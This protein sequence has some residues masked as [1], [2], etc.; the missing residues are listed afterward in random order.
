MDFVLGWVLRGIYVALGVGAAIWAFRWFKAN[1][2]STRERW[3]VRIAAAM[4]ILA[5]VY[6]VAHARLLLQRTEIEAARERY[7]VFGDPRRTELR[8]AEVRGW[9]LDCTGDPE[10]ALALYRERDGVVEREYPLGEG[11]ANFIGGGAD[12][13]V[14]DYTVEVLYAG[15]LRE[16]K[17]LTEMGALHP[18]GSDLPL[19]L[20]QAP[21]AEAW[22]QL[23]DTGRPGVVMAQDI[24]TGA[25]LAYAATGTATEPPLGLKQYSP[26]GSVFKL[27]LTALWWEHGLPDDIQIPCP[28]R[29]Q[30]TPRAVISNY[31]DVG[32]G[33]VEG[34]VGMLI[35]S[36]NTA[37]VWMAMEMKNR[38]GAEPFIEAYTRYG[39][40]AYEDEVPLDTIG[41]YWRASSDDWIRRMTPAPSRVRIS[42]STGDAEWAQ[43]AIGQGPVDVTVAGVSRFIQAIAND[44][45]MLPPTFETDLAG[46]APDGERVMSEET[47]RRLQDAMRQVVE[48]GTGRAAQ[49][50][51]SGTGWTMG[52]KTGTAQVAGRD[53]NG[54]FAGI[55]FSP[56]G[57]PR[58]SV[59]A[60]VVGGGPGG[61]MPTVAAARVARTL[62]EL[63]PV[64]DARQ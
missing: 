9:M 15:R 29:I 35:P 33:M 26:P 61:G 41:D 37:A 3:T 48:R 60:F 12:A 38:I 39:F 27:A 59:V 45:V 21:T 14:R 44:G 51:L 62:T 8:R 54:W 57:E 58:Y 53:D 19:T 7:A 18:A 6:M 63:S 17:D 43:L 24:R 22:R 32:Y 64:L 46:D 2:G 55:L 52:G 4:L 10:Q 56:E 30:V 36:C 13:D 42:E 11:G 1:W 49:P 47:A 40:V 16:P 31:G 28:A 5:G 34:P 25:V 23:V 20:C 50:I